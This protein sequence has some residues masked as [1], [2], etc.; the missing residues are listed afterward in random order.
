MS[1][2]SSPASF[3][4]RDL[5]RQPAK[6]LAAVRKYGSAEVRT[7]SGEIFTVAPKLAGTPDRRQT[8]KG[9]TEHFQNLWSKQRA[10]GLIP[11][12]DSENERINRIIAGEE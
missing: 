8:S 2:V 9:I 10:M 1:A 7:R 5:N 12:P 6:V 4:L 3:T 11:P